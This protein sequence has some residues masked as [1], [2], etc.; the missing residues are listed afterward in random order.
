MAVVEIKNPIPYNDEG[1]PTNG[2]INDLKMGIIP[3]DEKNDSINL[4]LNGN[5]CQ[6]CHCTS[7]ECPGHFGYIPLIKP[8]F[9][10]GYIK[11]C[12]RLL[13]CICI[14]CSNLLVTN[15]ETSGRSCPRGR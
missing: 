7:K 1:I 9:H 15:D 12:L 6:T 2:G 13:N 14:E 8:V 11:N 4:F 5:G 3:I 10:V